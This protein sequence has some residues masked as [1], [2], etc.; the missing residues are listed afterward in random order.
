MTGT[1][2]PRSWNLLSNAAK[3]TEK[4]AITIRSGA[5]GDVA[6]VS[7]TDQGAGIQSGDLPRL[8]QNFSQVRGERKTGGTGLGLAISKGIIEA[9]GG[10][11]GVESE[12]GKGSTFYFLLPFQVK[13]G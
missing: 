10:T 1:R 4:G 12:Y 7:V 9:H 8:F 2:S 3:F 6:R 5:E 13:G 11:I